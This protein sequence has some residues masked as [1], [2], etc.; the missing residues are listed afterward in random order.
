MLTTSFIAAT[1]LWRAIEAEGDDDGER[2]GAD[3]GSERGATKPSRDDCPPSVKM[4]ND[5]GT[6]RVTRRDDVW[7]VIVRSRNR[8]DFEGEISGSARVSERERER[9]RQKGRKGTSCPDS[10][11]RHREIVSPDPERK[12]EDHEE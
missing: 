1:S 2:N 8:G 9:E 11:E 6:G 7:A 5:E 3:D 12:L 4:R 10:R